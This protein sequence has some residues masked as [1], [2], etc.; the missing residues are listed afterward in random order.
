MKHNPVYKCKKELQ[1]YTYGKNKENAFCKKSKPLTIKVGDTYEYDEDLQEHLIVAKKPA[2][3]L[4]SCCDVYNDYWIEI[5]PDTI[6]EHFDLM[7]Y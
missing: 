7:E 3:H 2:E 6:E 5:Y 4:I 1:V